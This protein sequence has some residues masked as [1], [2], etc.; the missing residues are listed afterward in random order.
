MTETEN[1]ISNNVIKST[2]SVL[3]EP[4]EES[5]VNL[6]ISQLTQNADNADD[7][8][9]MQENNTIEDIILYDQQESITVAC[10]NNSHQEDSIS[11]EMTDK[12]IVRQEG[13]IVTADTINSNEANVSNESTEVSKGYTK[14]GK[15]RQRRK[16]EESNKVRQARKIEGKRQKLSIKN[17]CNETCKK[18]VIQ[19]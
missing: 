17:P 4:M 2:L 19:K 11:E 10:H 9:T 3:D 6:N 16:F 8:S 14:S 1:I 15:P 5:P 7:Q 13:E 12:Q 18:N